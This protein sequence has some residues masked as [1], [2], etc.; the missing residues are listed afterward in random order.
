MLLRFDAT[1]GGAKFSEIAEEVILLDIIEQP[2][3]MNVQKAQYGKG[4]GTLVSSVERTALSVQLVYVIRT[5][6]P[7]RWGEVH[8]LVTKWARNATTLT[9]NTRPGKKLVGK[10]YTA[11]ARNSALRWT[12]EQTITF[13]AYEVPYWQDE[14]VSV[15]TFISRGD[16]VKVNCMCTADHV[17]LELMITNDTSK[18][19]TEVMIVVA[20]TYKMHLK[21]LN[22]VTPPQEGL[23]EEHALVI[24]AKDGRTTRIFVTDEQNTSML[25]T[26]TEDSVDVLEAITTEPTQVYFWADQS[27][28]C[29]LNCRR[30]WL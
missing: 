12:D 5:Q 30:W 26:R 18:P 29:W 1:N 4:P 10:F 3:E 22:L 28:T 9:V 16:T 17:P 20:G 7:V 6:D 21:G 8:D 2:A 27:A 24:E 15:S 23:V 11:P 19:I 14:N 13:T 25:H